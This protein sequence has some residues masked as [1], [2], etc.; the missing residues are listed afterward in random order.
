MA[1]LQ[2][3]IADEINQLLPEHYAKTDDL[4]LLAR[5]QYFG[6]L[7]NLEST[8]TPKTTVTP[9]PTKTPRPAPTPTVDLNAVWHVQPYE[10]IDIQDSSFGTRTHHAIN[11]VASDAKTREERLATL[12]AYAT[13][14]YRQC[15]I[16]D[17][18][19]I[20]LWASSQFWW[21][22]AKVVFS[23]DRCGWVGDDCGRSH[24]HEAQ[25]SAAVFTEEQLRIH[26]LERASAGCYLEPV[27]HECRRA[28][29]VSR[30][31]GLFEPVDIPAEGACYSDLGVLWEDTN[32]TPCQQLELLWVMPDEEWRELDY[33]CAEERH[34]QFIASQ[35]AMDLDLVAQNHTAMS[36]LLYDD[37]TKLLN[38]EIPRAEHRQDLKRIAY[39]SPTP[40]PAWYEGDIA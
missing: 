31:L 32:R 29:L 14:A 20:S 6:G 37:D 4:K 36:G 5:M 21:L 35:L 16:E 24:W 27:C 38:I 39:V 33:T 30:R 13:H 22:L 12:M 1:S 19:S 17:A 40:T 15:E 8:R 3:K 18:A 10:V 28:T 2:D 34:H 23:A 7:T 26:V 25:A 9:K 11:L